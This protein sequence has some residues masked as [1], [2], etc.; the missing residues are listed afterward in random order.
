MASLLA[1]MNR[2]VSYFTE[3]NSDDC[4]RSDAEL[5][6]DYETN[7]VDCARSEEV[8]LSIVNDDRNWEECIVCDRFVKPQYYIKEER[9]CICCHEISLGKDKQCSSCGEVKHISL[10]RNPNY[11]IVSNAPAILRD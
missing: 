8:A 7:N 10:F 1:L 3:S 11:F 4:G 2:D 9:I 6:T 5:S